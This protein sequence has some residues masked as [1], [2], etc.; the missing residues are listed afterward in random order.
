V[1]RR[2]GKEKFD[3]VCKS[4][5]GS[6]VRTEIKLDKSKTYILYHRAAFH[7]VIRDFTRCSLMDFI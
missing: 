4:E 3:D 2:I 7:T 1:E 6:D 5:V